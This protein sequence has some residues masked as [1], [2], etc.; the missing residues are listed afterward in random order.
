MVRLRADPGFNPDLNQIVD[1][2]AITKM[3]LTQKQIIDLAGRSIF[4][5]R[6]RR[7][8]VVSSDLHYGLTRMFATY[9][10]I[11]AGQEVMVFQDLPTALNWLRL[12]ADLNFDTAIRIATGITSRDENRLG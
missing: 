9:R 2:R 7:A 11:Q 4:N 10:E 5:A 8:F 6:S 12:P 1:C 3:D